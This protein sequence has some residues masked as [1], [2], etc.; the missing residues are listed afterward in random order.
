MTFPPEYPEMLQQIALTLKGGME[1]DG[2]DPDAAGK[3][4][5][6]AVEDLRFVFGG[7]VFYLPQGKTY[8]MSRQEKE[9]FEAYTTGPGA[10]TRARIDQLATQYKVSDRAIYRA[11]ARAKLRENAEQQGTLNL[12]V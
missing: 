3:I 10:Y 5:F 4:A 12:E 11:V 6:D 8:D 1:R 9:I 7:H 2:I